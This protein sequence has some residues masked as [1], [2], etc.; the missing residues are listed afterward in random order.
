VT[1]PVVTAQAMQMVP[2]AMT[3]IGGASPGSGSGPGGGDGRGPGSGTGEGPGA[4]AG[5][6][7]GYG[8]DIVPP[9]TGV[10]SP[11]LMKEVRP[12]YT[13]MAMQAKVQGKIEMQAV[14]LPDGSVDPSRIRI[15][16][17]LD[18]T[19]GLD[20]Q[21]IIAVKQWHFRPG[22]RRGEPVAMWVDVELTFTLR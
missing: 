9:G 20:Q 13:A 19:F 11:Q 6:V 3:E 17:S 10:T 2:G 4:G 14:V 8:G 15:T 22:T 5:R 7:P 16:R 18:A 1:I 12:S 21:A